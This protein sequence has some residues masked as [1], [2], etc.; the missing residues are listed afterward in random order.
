VNNKATNLSILPSLKQ[1][2]PEIEFAF[3]DHHFYREVAGVKYAVL[4][5]TSPSH[6]VHT[7]CTDQHNECNSKHSNTIHKIPKQIT[8][9]TKISEKIL[10]RLATCHDVSSGHGSTSGDS[11]GM[12]GGRG[13][14]VGDWFWFTIGAGIYLVHTVDGVVYHG[15]CRDLLSF[16]LSGKN[17]SF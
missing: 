4:F 10:Q 6:M 14:A 1:I 17:D 15:S 11:G 7:T 2:Y 12:D 5:S 13:V 8:R 16:Y 9:N 3:E